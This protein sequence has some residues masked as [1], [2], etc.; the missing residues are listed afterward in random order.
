M[1]RKPS[2]NWQQRNEGA[3]IRTVRTASAIATDGAK[4]ARGGV[5]ALRGIG[6]YCFAAL[7]GFAAIMSTLTG[8]LQGGIFI[9]AL[10]AF[11]VWRGNKAFA[12]ARTG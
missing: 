8:G 4:L 2:E 5:H 6:C 12:K 11:M 7:W 3:A 9:G 10:A 1:I